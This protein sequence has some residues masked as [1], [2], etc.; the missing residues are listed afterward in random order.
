MKINDFKQGDI[1]KVTNP[2]N[3]IIIERAIVFAVNFRNSGAVVIMFKSED[4]T[5]ANNLSFYPESEQNLI[6]EK[7][8]EMKKSK[9]SKK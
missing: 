1:L 7:I 6:I 2:T 3:G 8:G 9:K 5:T 4:G